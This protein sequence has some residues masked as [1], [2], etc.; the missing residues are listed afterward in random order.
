M[1]HRPSA[2]AAV[3]HQP[4]AADVDRRRFRGASLL[5]FGG[6]GGVGKTTVAAAVALRLA[7]ADP[8]APRAAALHRSGA[9]ARRR[10]RARRSAIAPR[11][12]P[13][14][15][16]EP[17]RPRARRGRARSPRAAPSSRRRSTRSPSALGIERRRRRRSARRE[18]M[19]LAPP[20]I[21][22]LFGIL[23]VVDAARRL[24]RH[25]RRHRAD[26]PRAAAAR[27]ARGGA[28]VDAGAAA[29]AA[30]VPIAGPSRSAGGGARRGVEIDP[31]A[32]SR[33]C[34]IAKTTRF[35]VVT[36]AAELPRRETERLLARL[37][38]LHLVGAG[39]RRQR[40]DAGARPLPALPRRRGRGA[41]R[42]R[43]A[44]PGLRPARCAIIQTPLSAPP[45]RGVKALE[46]WAR[47]VART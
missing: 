15:A 28:R 33:C 25:R 29:R 38:R 37:R 44:A 13:G 47:V 34:A 45:P 17:G 35:I 16:A 36:R 12:V 11:P 10:L 5:F 42:A 30:E 39:G 40:A 2:A 14:G 19:N 41:A 43:G 24:R 8:D 18:L 32:A 31:R 46:R 6:K 21:D 4:I 26:R 23:S 7:R 9:L 27:D 22:E 3:S 1:R 20:G